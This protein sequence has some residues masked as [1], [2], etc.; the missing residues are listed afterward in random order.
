[1]SAVIDEPLTEQKPLLKFRTAAELVHHLGDI[2]LSRIRLHPPIGTATEADLIRAEKPVC[3]LI[4]GILVEKAMG[5]FE[6]RLGFILGAIIN[7][8]LRVNPIG[9]VMGEGALTRMQSGNVRVPD[10]SFVRWERLDE[11]RVPRDPIC[12]VIPNLAVEV[13]SATNTHREIERKRQQFFDSGVELVWIIEPELM[14]VEV[15]SSPK[16]CHVADRRDVLDGGDVLPGF[17]ISIED[18]FRQAD[19]NPAAM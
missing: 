7:D 16:I 4:D 10:V 8:W 3:E 6:S 17:Q 11:Q 14:T 2:P 5:Y 19:G 9:Y 13:L 12:H 15:W 1:M 18:L